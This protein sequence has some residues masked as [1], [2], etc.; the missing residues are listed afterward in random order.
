MATIL[1]IKVDGSGYD[2]P[3]VFI[4]LDGPVVQRAI[5]S[6]QSSA[7]FYLDGSVEVEEATT[8]DDAVPIMSIDAFLVTAANCIGADS[9]EIEALPKLW[10]SGQEWSR[11]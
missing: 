9:E 6:W 1:Y 7:A 10:K 11:T 2:E 8:L 5:R 4:V 3:S